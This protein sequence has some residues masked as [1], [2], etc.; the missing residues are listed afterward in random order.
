MGIQ[1]WCQVIIHSIWD[2]LLLE[3][4]VVCGL[5]YGKNVR[6]TQIMK[7]HIYKHLIVLLP[8]KDLTQNTIRYEI[9]SVLLPMHMV[10]KAVKV[11]F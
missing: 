11:K 7:C 10:A 9:Y 2:S 6:T 3:P 1:L 4:S 5:L 8:T